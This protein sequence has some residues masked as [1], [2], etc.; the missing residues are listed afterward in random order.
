M[1]RLLTLYHEFG[2]SPWL[3]NLKRGYITSGQLTKLVA[4]GI[5]GLTSNPTI[6]QKAIQGS[7]D[8][9]E[10][11]AALA[12]QNRPI[13][14]DYWA[15][16]LRDI[17][18]ALDAFAPLYHQSYGRDGF[19]S[20]EVDPGLAHDATGTELAARQLHEQIDRPNLMVKIPATEEGVPAIRQMIAEGRN[21]NVTLIF[22]LDRYQDVMEAYLSGLEQY[23]KVEGS[24]LS[25]V[26]SVASFFISRVDTE[27]DQRLD[28]DGSPEA[29][30]LR[31]KGAVAQGKLAY[32]LFQQTFSGERWEALA[33][34]GAVVQRPLWASTSTKN[35]A[36][37]DTLYVDELIGPDTV[38]TLPD[39]TIEA[40][41]D[42]GTLARTVD[43]GVD[44]AYA[45]WEGLANVG[46][47]VDDVA[48]KLEREGVSSF[49]KSFDELLG[50]L[51]AKG[52]ELRAR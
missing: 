2:Q 13:I 44:E 19:V 27:I 16:V 15:M 5:R 45:V 14:D 33:A 10:Q 8:Y 34:R 20:V 43:V 40:F 30:A 36:Y 29:L 49:Q 22:S 23:S 24:D 21:I 37:P 11:F 39:S 38:N 41:A 46:V 51:E 18:S 9:D 48:D 3:D 26:A 4:G 25:K 6:F 28:A 32:Q 1:D 17:N 7:A 12:A 52:V 31:G 47:D 35:P 50:A 42:H